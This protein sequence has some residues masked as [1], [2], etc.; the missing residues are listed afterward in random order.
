MPTE[1]SGIPPLDVGGVILNGDVVL[2]LSLGRANGGVASP[3]L[4]TAPTLAGEVGRCGDVVLCLS[5]G[6]ANGGVAHP[7]VARVRTLVGEMGLPPTRGAARLLCTVAGE[8]GRCWRIAGGALRP[9][10]SSD[11]VGDRAKTL[12]GLGPLQSA[13]NMGS[14]G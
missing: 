8:T 9:R 2:C 10:G 7:D 4:E 11:V 13:K 1:A 12:C 14:C 6:E 5:L 3:D